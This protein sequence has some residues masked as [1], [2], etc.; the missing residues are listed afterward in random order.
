MN[1][2]IIVNKNKQINYYNKSAGKE[3]NEFSPGDKV[4]IQNKL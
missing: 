4:V 3:E 2:E 1:K